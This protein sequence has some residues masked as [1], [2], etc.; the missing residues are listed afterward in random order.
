MCQW[1][2]L[3]LI[4]Q[5]C[6]STCKMISSTIDYRCRVQHFPQNLNRLSPFHPLYC[7]AIHFETILILFLCILGFWSPVYPALADSPVEMSERGH[8]YIKWFGV[9]CSAICSTN[10][11]YQ[12]IA[13]ISIIRITGTKLSIGLVGWW[14]VTLKSMQGITGLCRGKPFDFTESFYIAL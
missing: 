4:V 7:F 9:A 11:C 12:S 2:I 5:L 13:R 14:F 10:H 1:R 6:I 8:A 3:M